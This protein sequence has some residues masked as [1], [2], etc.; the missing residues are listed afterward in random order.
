VLAKIGQRGNF[1][2]H[3]RLPFNDVQHILVPLMQRALGHGPDLVKLEFLFVIELVEISKEEILI[4]HI[5]PEI[6]PVL[7]R[8]GKKIT[9]ATLGDKCC[10]G[11]L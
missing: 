4:F 6:E 11:D 2:E 1:R 7:D 10:P 5:V 8:L 3:S 9:A